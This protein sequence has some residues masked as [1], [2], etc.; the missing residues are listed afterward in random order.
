MS[1]TPSMLSE[2]LIGRAHAESVEINAPGLSFIVSSASAKKY[3]KEKDK[4]RW[5]HLN[6]KLLSSLPFGANDLIAELAGLSPVSEKTKEYMV[7]P[8]AVQEHR[9]KQHKD[10]RESRRGKQ[11]G[12]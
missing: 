1:V 7:V 10:R 3:D 5:A 4:V 2:R 6:M 11:G 12:Q 8:K 9:A